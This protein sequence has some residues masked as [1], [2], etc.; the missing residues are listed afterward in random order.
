MIDGKIQNRYANET[1]NSS[2]DYYQALSQNKNL[3]FY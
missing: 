1:F 2:A 3:N